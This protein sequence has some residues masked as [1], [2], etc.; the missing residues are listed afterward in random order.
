MEM[1]LNQIMSTHP[2]TVRYKDDLSSAFLRMRREGFRHM[3]VIDDFGS[4]VGIISD[5][6]FQ[7]AMWPIH[8]PDAH[9]LPDSPHFRK[10]A[11]V[12]DYMSWPVKNFPENTSLLIA[13]ETMIDAKISSIVITRDDEMIGIV[14]HED[15]LRVLAN[16]LK[17]PSSI[18]ER[19]LE[20]AYN[21]PIGKV[22]VLLSAAG[23]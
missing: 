7:R 9:G 13:I 1:K 18:R 22:N 5:R 4:V 11:K 12:A 20:L 8:T 16:L 21:T 23:V 2:T 15:L 10:D 19:A 17:E 14:T 6:D 3:P